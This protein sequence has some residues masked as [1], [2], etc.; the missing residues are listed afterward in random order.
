[1]KKKVSQLLKIGVV[2]VPPVDFAGER[3]KPQAVP[4]A[5]V[6]LVAGVCVASNDVVVLEDV[7]HRNLTAPGR[8]GLDTQRVACH[9][10]DVVRAQGLH[11]R[12]ATLLGYYAVPAALER[13]ECLRRL[14]H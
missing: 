11:L 13:L 1:M 2:G 14:T 6:G 3:S 8:P 9:P 10:V 7:L 4:G 12:L 5:L